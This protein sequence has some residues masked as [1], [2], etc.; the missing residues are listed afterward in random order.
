MGLR[1]RLAEVAVLTVNR[2][3]TAWCAPLTKTAVGLTAGSKKARSRLGSRKTVQSTAPVEISQVVADATITPS[4]NQ[5]FS[6]RS[7]VAKDSC[8]ST[9]ESQGRSA[10]QKRIGGA[11]NKAEHPG[12]DLRT[13]QA[14]FPES[15]STGPQARDGQWHRRRLGPKHGGLIF[16][17]LL[18]NFPQGSCGMTTDAHEKATRKNSTRAQSPFAVGF[19]EACPQRFSFAPSHHEKV[20]GR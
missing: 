15:S 2:R 17:I 19:A 18:Q 12:S 4:V 7:F 8:I 11:Y 13:N 6:R 3:S 14:T 20:A 1:L 9:S 5:A 10:M 16:N